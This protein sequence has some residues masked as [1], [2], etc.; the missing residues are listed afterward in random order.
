MM[1]YPAALPMS[2]VTLY[3]DMFGACS[4]HLCVIIS[5]VAISQPRD[6]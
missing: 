4:L 1:C 3:R 2:T 5:I 6:V